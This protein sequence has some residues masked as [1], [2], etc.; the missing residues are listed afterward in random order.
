MTPY[1]DDG[2]STIYHADCL[3]VLPM[4]TDVGLVL[5]SPPYNLSGD[6]N[7]PGHPYTNGSSTAVDLSK[8]YGLH[9][10][11][12]PHADYVAWQQQV[13]R[14]CWGTLVDTGAIFYN[15]KP[16]V[17]GNTVRLPL[18]LVPD[19][20]PLRQIVTW[21]RG[22]GFNRQFTYF[23][24][25]YEWVLILARPAFR[26]TTRSVDDV[27]RIPF[28]GGGGHP[29]PFPLRLARTAI[30]AT[31]AHLVL[32]PFMGSGTALRAAKDCGR[33]AI[34]I[35]IDERFCEMAAKRLSQEVLD[36]WAG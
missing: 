14:V 36:L 16:I 2:Q 1:Y 7:K 18:E 22:S 10:D 35:E 28:E 4:L 3:D 23:V 15:H 32:D 8:G 17:R 31:S 26:I 27:W 19:E 11:A 24:P 20:V 34:G 21:D 29:A 25:T 12:M 6:G 5:T 9:D 30:G 33:R 13:L